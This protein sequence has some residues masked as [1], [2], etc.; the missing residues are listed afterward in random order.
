M[1]HSI[2]EITSIYQRLNSELEELNKNAIR[3]VKLDLPEMN[4]KWLEKTMKG[5]LNLKGKKKLL[6]TQIGY[7]RMNIFNEYYERVK[8]AKQNNELDKGVELM[9][10]HAKIAKLFI[11][12]KEQSHLVKRLKEMLGIKDIDRNEYLTKWK[13]LYETWQQEKKHSSML[14]DD[15]HRLAEFEKLRMAF[16]ELYTFSFSVDNYPPLR[17]RR[18][19]HSP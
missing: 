10:E 7:L 15:S 2:E 19:D 16:L 17:Y 5:T 8:L 18:G 13:N 9:N 12:P 3:D 6:L 4:E 1:E 11:H 14:T